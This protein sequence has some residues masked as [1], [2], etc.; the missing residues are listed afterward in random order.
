MGGDSVLLRRDGRA[1]LVAGRLAQPRRGGGYGE[2]S[3]AGLQALDEIRDRPELQ[4][5]Y[6][7]PATLGELYERSGQLD[8]A[9]GCYRDALALATNGT[10]QRFLRSKLGRLDASCVVAR[11]SP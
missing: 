1:Q 7:L 11:T 2:G 5:Y 9:V 6:L 10:E 3:A 4:R 8:L